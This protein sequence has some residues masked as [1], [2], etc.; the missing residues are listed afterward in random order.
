MRKV[1]LTLIFLNILQIA[2]SYG[3]RAAFAY[4]FGASELLDIYLVCLIIPSLLV[5]FFQGLGT[6]TTPTCARVEEE[7]G[8]VAA[9]RVWGSLFWMT[10]AFV[11]LVLPLML[12]KLSFLLKF[13]G[14]NLTP[15]QEEIAI[16][17]S[18]YLLPAQFGIQGMSYFLSTLLTYKKHFVVCKLG[19]TM[20][21]VILTLGI[22][23]FGHR[24]GV[25]AAVVSILAGSIAELALN[26][27]FARRYVDFTALFDLL[28]GQLPPRLKR[29]AGQAVPV[30]MLALNGQ[31]MAAAD[32]IMATAIGGG[33]L[34]ILNYTYA[35]FQIPQLVF[36]KAST[37]V[38]F[39][40]LF[41]QAARNDFAAF[42]GN[43]Y[44]TIESTMMWIF[45]C[46]VGMLVLRVPL[47]SV[48]LEHGNFSAAD[49]E[50][51]ASLLVFFA[52]ISILWAMWL[53]LGR[54]LV[55]L[56]KSHS[57]MLIEFTMTALSIGLNFALRPLLGLRGL[58]LSTAIAMT[59]TIAGFLLVIR[60]EIKVL[61]ITRVFRIISRPFIASSVMGLVCSLLLLA[62]ALTR[63]SALAQVIVVSAI[64]CP[65]YFALAAAMK[66]P[67]AV[68]IVHWL[69]VRTGALLAPV[70]QTE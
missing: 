4:Y 40:D 57:V 63:T 29:I 49:T 46:T 50:S 30:M 54:P 39:P 26:F 19:T 27:F 66:I 13:S 22:V 47:V 18:R 31:L 16:S 34:S 1:T 38:K 35:I 6:A 23:L 69:G 60:S 15:G 67:D 41:R 61:E 33:A 51:V 52:P 2:G 28:K 17:F 20:T 9:K 45:P 70:R 65:L 44:E 42:A 64:G 36:T 3:Q 43:I 8:E 48:M 5:V 7:S 14:G 10:L 55:A 68:R 59:F 56:E 62:M 25:F 37:T 11:C 32:S 58:V 24:I 53:C 12:W 21:T